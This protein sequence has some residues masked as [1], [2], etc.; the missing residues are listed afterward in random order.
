MWPF[1][2]LYV[3]FVILLTWEKIAMWPFATLYVIFV[4]FRSPGKKLP[5]DFLQS[6]FYMPLLLISHILIFS[7]TITWWIRIK[8][9]K[10]HIREV[11]YKNSSFRLD[12][13]KKFAT[14]LLVNLFYLWLTETLQV[15]SFET[16]SPKDF[17]IVTNNVYEILYRNSS[18]HM[19]RRKMANPLQRFLI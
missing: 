4:I 5:C 1:A 16:T 19:D 18:F 14:I 7:S 2:T 8:L 13:T 12:L 9:Y 10:N 17:L 6:A 15:F 11:L 3:I